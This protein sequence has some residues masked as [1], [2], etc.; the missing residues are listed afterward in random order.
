MTPAG[1]AIASSRISANLTSSGARS[2]ETWLENPKAF[3]MIC[4]YMI[5]VSA[6]SLQRND[7]VF[8]MYISTATSFCFD[9]SSVFL[10]QEIVSSWQD[11]IPRSGPWFYRASPRLFTAKILVPPSAAY[12]SIS[13]KVL[14]G[15]AARVLI[16]WL[17]ARLAELTDDSIHHKQLNWQQR[18]FVWWNIFP[19][20]F[21]V[22]KYVVQNRA[23]SGKDSMFA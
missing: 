14:K 18:K 7:P 10:L 4:T 12:T 1:L 21:L 8:K 3:Y 17:T 22:V 13:Q 19:K 16:Y 11:W 5:C 15:I 23:F 2:N 20:K 6:G 9:M